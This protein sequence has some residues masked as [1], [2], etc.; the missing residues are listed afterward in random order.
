MKSDR[1]PD[2]AVYL[3]KQPPGENP[4]TRWVPHI[5]VEVLS[6]GS[7]QRDTVQKREEY[8]RVSVREYWILDPKTRRMTVLVRAGDT[9][10]DSVVAPGSVYRTH[11]LPGLEVRPDELFGRAK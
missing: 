11:I 5:V 3:D 1:H 4:W 10:E 7:K 6:K 8:L 9:W 2:Q